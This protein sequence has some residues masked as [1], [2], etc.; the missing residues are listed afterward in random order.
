MYRKDRVGKKGG[1]VAVLVSTALHSR[2]FD[3]VNTSESLEICGVQIKT[4]KGQLGIFSIY[5]PPNTNACT[6]RSE[7]S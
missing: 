4:N 2:E 7:A 6:F 5:R 1:G 3:V